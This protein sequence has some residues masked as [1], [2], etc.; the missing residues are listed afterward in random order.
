MIQCRR[1]LLGVA[2]AAVLATL[3]PAG[4]IAE[5]QGSFQRTLQV[6]GPV[7]L[8][9]ETGSGDLEIRGGSSNT[10]QVNGRIRVSRWSDNAEEK[11]RRLQSN[12][13]IEQNGNRILV[14]RIEDPDLKRNVSI[15]YIIEVP[16]DTRL[17]ASTGSGNEKIQSIRG[18]VQ[19]RSG[20][21]DLMVSNI[22]GGMDAQTGSGNMRLSNLQSGVRVRTGSGDIE[23]DAIAGAFEGEAGS[24]NVRLVDTAA[25]DVRVGSGS[26][27]LTVRGVKGALD[28]R[29]GSGNV[30]VEG[31]P[32]GNWRL[33]AGSGDIRLSLPQDAS[34]DLDA[35]SHSGEVTVNRPITVQ[36]TIGRHSVRGEDRVRRN[37]DQVR[38]PLLRASASILS[39]QCVFLCRDKP[40]PIVQ[41]CLGYNRNPK[42][43]TYPY[44]V[45]GKQS[46]DFS[47]GEQHEE[48]AVDVSGRGCVPG[49]CCFR[50]GHFQFERRAKL[51][52]GQRHRQER[53]GC[54]GSAE[55]HQRH[56]Q[57]R[58]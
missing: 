11:V 34:F 6:S 42:T 3:A 35:S 50:A 20:S 10:V 31:T 33:S 30:E 39:P 57:G 41:H 17:T 16:Q 27:E 2:S 54:Q 52:H 44:L 1:I 25:G 53:Q 23:A 12:P 49:N 4:A 38:A 46:P 26:G 24:G 8:Q 47:E 19:A 45:R 48:A 13:P 51:D 43:G 55:D 22:S 14:G 21:G 15:S 7:E 37:R 58:R 32:A 29:T 9:V 28:L 40:L 18:P 56:G 36:G 5:T